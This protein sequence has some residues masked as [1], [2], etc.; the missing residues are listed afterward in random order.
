MGLKKFSFIVMLA[1][2]MLTVAQ[3]DQPAVVV[4]DVPDFVAV[5][6]TWGP[7]QFYRP[8]GLKAI[9]MDDWQDLA[10]TYPINGEPLNTDRQGWLPLTGVTTIWAQMHPALTA[11]ADTTAP[12]LLVN[13]HQGDGDFKDFTL[14]YHNSLGP[15]TRYAWTSKL[16]SH[17]RFLGVQLYDEQRHRI[18]V[19][20]RFDEQVLRVEVGY[21]HQVNPLY[22]Y[23]LDTTL[24][25]WDFNNNLQL[26]SDRWD[27]NI[28]WQN[29]D[30][31]SLGSEFF[32]WVQGATWEW[33]AAQRRSL[34]SLAYFGHRFKVGNGSPAELKVGIISKRLGGDRSKRHF[35][36][37]RLPRFEYKILSLDLG[38]K[39]L[40]QWRFMPMIKAHLDYDPIKLTYQTRQL[41]DEQTLN[42]KLTTT[43]IH[44]FNSLI[45]YPVFEISLGGWQGQNDQGAVSG[46]E[47]YTRLSF[48]WMMK[49]KLGGSL[50]DPGADWIFAEKQIVW[51]LDQDLVLFDQAMFANLKIWGRHL[52][53][54]QQGFLDPQSLLVRPT[55]ITST[56]PVLHLLNYTIH[57]QV[58]TLIIG[59]T[60]TNMLQDNLWSQYLPAA[61]TL[62][63]PIMAN[64]FTESRFRYLSLIWVFDN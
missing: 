34:S 2:P 49:L 36:E 47:A 23:E 7:L 39:N 53:D 25:I 24:Q 52:I 61:S 60:D 5:A 6:G 9:V 62:E 31:N 30:S 35:I 20:D 11:E 18:Q 1:M 17:Q 32:A 44:Q 59:F 26:R 40:G 63:Y 12:S 29:L 46:L 43:T 4:Q 33:P 10:T 58:S 28:H 38:L 64:Q 16:R 14:W 48:P 3:L 51:E 21:D 42:P 22:M 45:K 54:P 15:A 56:V 57:V 13:Y 41:I 8:F 37:A 27:G 19:E 50:V 55:S